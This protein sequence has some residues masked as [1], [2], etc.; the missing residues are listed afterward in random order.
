M[1]ARWRSN[2]SSTLFQKSI[3]GYISR[4]ARPSLSKTTPKSKEVAQPP[5]PTKT[6]RKRQREDDDDD[7]DAARPPAQDTRLPRSAKKRLD[8]GSTSRHADEDDASLHESYIAGATDDD[9]GS[10]FESENYSDPE[11]DEEDMFLSSDDN[12]DEASQPEDE[13][14]QPDEDNEDD[15]DQPDEDNEEEAD[16]PDEDNEDED[17]QF[18]DADQTD[19]DADIHH[20]DDDDMK[21]TQYSLNIPLRDKDL[22]NI[23]VTSTEVTSMVGKVLPALSSRKMKNFYRTIAGH[24]E[25][26][27]PFRIPARSRHPT[28]CSL[29]NPDFD[30]LWKHSVDGERA[31]DLGDPSLLPKWLNMSEDGLVKPIDSFTDTLLL[32]S[33]YPT[34]S[35]E[36]SVHNRYGTVDDMS[37]VCMWML[38]AKSGYHMADLR[39]HGVTR[40]DI[41]ARR[42]DRNLIPGSDGD[43]LFRITPLNQSGTVSYAGIDEVQ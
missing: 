16:Q 8:A 35:E 19:N 24:L 7:T 38:Y 28:T 15:A 5:K 33:S 23:D 3:D 42:L 26:S 32:I 9:T 21:E 12:E 25:K 30:L 41:M 34:A 29:V 17:S 40:I 18:D 37:N 31:L 39:S 20:A 43:K 10:V 4:T 11:G 14:D 36:G 27:P 6:Q 22:F 13:A 2:L 1:L